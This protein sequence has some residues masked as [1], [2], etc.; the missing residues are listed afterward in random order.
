MLKV[1][2]KDRGGVR[3]TYIE[4]GKF[5][6]FAL[7]REGEGGKRL[8]QALPFPAPVTGMLDLRCAFCVHF[9]AKELIK[10]DR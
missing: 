7:S 3:F 8:K 5:L 1:E 6:F 10:K 2:K 4:G 9:S